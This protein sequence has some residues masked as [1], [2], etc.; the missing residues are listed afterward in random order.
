MELGYLHVFVQIMCETSQEIYALRNSSVSL[1]L[2]L[3]LDLEFLNSNLSITRFWWGGVTWKKG[4][5][6]KT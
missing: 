3:P 1:G 6:W 2:L 5:T 4:N